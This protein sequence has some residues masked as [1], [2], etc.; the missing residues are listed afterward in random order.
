MHFVSFKDQDRC[1]ESWNWPQIT[2]MKQ[3]LA[4]FSNRCLAFSTKIR[5]NPA[6]Q[7]H[8]WR[9]ETLGIHKVAVKLAISS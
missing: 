3:I 4:D 7:R 1:I 5:V 9:I 8:P 6:H 2:R